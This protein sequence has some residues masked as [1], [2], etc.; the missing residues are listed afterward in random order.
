MLVFPRCAI[1]LLAVCVSC[2]VPR[3]L[4]QQVTPP[5]LPLF[6][7]WLMSEILDQEIPPRQ[8]RTNPRVIKKPRSKFKSKKRAQRSNTSQLQTLTFTLAPTAA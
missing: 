4:F 6:V 5:T 2:V 7:S 3:P 1:D 8:G